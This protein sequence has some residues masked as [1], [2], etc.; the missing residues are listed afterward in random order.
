MNWEDHIN[1]SERPTCSA[2][3]SPGDQV[4][5]CHGK[6]GPGKIGPPGPILDPKTDPARPNLVDQNRS[7]RTSFSIQNWSSLA[8][9]GPG[10]RL[11]LIEFNEMIL[12]IAGPQGQHRHIL[13]I[14]SPPYDTVTV[15]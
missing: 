15:P 6:I 4:M 13:A 2:A 12:V 8:K 9:I 11:R 3:S 1:L 10:P 14:K 7:Y 5:A